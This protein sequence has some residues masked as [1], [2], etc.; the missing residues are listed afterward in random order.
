MS[1]EIIF[2]MFV[3]TYLVIDFVWNRGVEKRLERIE[4]ALKDKP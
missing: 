4:R 1:I 2:G 3:V